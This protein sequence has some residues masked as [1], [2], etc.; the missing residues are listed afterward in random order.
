[1]TAHNH[2]VVPVRQWRDVPS[3]HATS[4]NGTALYVKGGST[5]V[6]LAALAD[7]LR[8]PVV[9]WLVLDDQ[10]G[11][12]LAARDI[13]TLCWLTEVSGV[14]VSRPSG[15]VQ[16]NAHVVAALLSRDDV[17][18]S[19]G[20]VTLTSAFNRPLPPRPP[21]VWAAHDLPDADRVRL[22]RVDDEGESSAISPE[23]WSE[24]HAWGD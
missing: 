23:E 6:I 7:E 4:P 9:V 20:D 19:V 14:I 3:R 24:R 10:Y 18:L 2:L 12:P 8:R 1:M 22:S 17:T 21:T 15:Q 16:E 5:T 13:G 11:A